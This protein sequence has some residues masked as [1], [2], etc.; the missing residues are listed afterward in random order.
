MSSNRVL[1]SILQNTLDYNII[2]LPLFP[3]HFVS[4]F[5]SSFLSFFLSSY[6]VVPLFSSP[7]P[8]S[9]CTLPPTLPSVVNC[10]PMLPCSWNGPPTCCAVPPTAPLDVKCFPMAPSA[11]KTDYDTPHI[12]ISNSPRATVQS[13]SSRTKCCV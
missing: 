13:N 1:G 10:F 5:L 3:P 12:S 7:F 4:S 8:N 11:E 2:H 6:F 9:C